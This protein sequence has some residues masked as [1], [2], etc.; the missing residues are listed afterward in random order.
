MEFNFEI[1]QMEEEQSVT[2]PF[3]VAKNS[4]WVAEEVLFVVAKA[5]GYNLDLC[6]KTCQ[7]WVMIAGAGCETRVIEDPGENVMNALKALATDKPYIALFYA[8]TPLVDKQ[9]FYKIMDRFCAQSMNALALPRGFVFK[10]DY[11]NSNSEMASTLTYKETLSSFT[12]VMDAEDF[13]K[14]SDYLFS[15]IRNF[16]LRN[17]IIMYGANSIFI[18]ADV[19]IEAGAVIYQNNILRGQTYIGRGVT[20]DAN[21]I[22]SDSIIADEA[23][24]MSSVIDKSKISKGTSVGP[25]EKIIGSER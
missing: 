20:L 3:M 17:G 14:I 16:H 2:L 25:F 23:Y 21:N 10:T 22:I 11:V 13:V 1:D 19:E 8:D 24:V 4:E 7:D 12:R 6:G 18:D 15:K 9:L 5:S